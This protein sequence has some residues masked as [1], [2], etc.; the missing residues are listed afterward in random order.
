[1]SI[2]WQWLSSTALTLTQ[3]YDGLALRSQVF[4]VEQQC[5]YQDVDGLDLQ[6]D[7]YH[8]FAYRQQQLLAYARVLHTDSP[9]VVIGRV[10]VDARH[11]GQGLGA[12]LMTQLMQQIATHWPSKDR[13][14]SAQA[15][16]QHFYGKFGFCTVTDQYLEDG[17]PHVG[18]HLN[19]QADQASS[20]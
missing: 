1:M 11:R 13:Y 15:H 6:S 20:E 10:V 12:A 3:L 4:V 19:V 2:E 17:I 5:A 14:L 16:L 8:I 9:C 18:M 7:S